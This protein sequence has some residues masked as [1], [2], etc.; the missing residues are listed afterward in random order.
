MND[1]PDI[2]PKILRLRGFPFD[3]FFKKIASFLFF[4]VGERDEPPIF[5][6]SFSHMLEDH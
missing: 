3:L 6:T 2:N 1:F 5:C 4:S